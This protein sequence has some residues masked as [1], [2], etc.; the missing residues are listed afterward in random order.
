MSSVVWIRLGR[1]LLALV[2]CILSFLPAV[3]FLELSPV[4]DKKLIRS[5][6][7][8]GFHLP[9]EIF[10]SLVGLLTIFVA[11]SLWILPSA[12]AIGFAL[13]APVKSRVLRGVT[14]CLLLT[15][16]Y[17]WWVNAPGAVIASR[18]VA[19]AVSILLVSAAV[20]SLLR[21]RITNL[22]FVA[23]A[24]SFALLT[25]PAWI[26]LF[27]APPEP[28]SAQ[29]LWSVVLQRKA[30]QGMNTGSAFNSRRQ[31]VFA[32][33]RLVVSFDSGPAPYEGKQPMSNFR[34]LSLD[35]QT[36][37]VLNSKQ[38]VGHWGYMPLLFA[39][40]DGRAILQ[41]ESLKSLNPDLTDA[42]AQFMPDRGRVDQMSSDGSVMAW[43]TAPGTT[44]LDSR[45][46]TPLPQH[47]DESAPTSVSKRAV[48]TDNMRWYG[49]Y[50]DDH[51]FVT[52]T[53][54]SGKHLIF[55]DKCGGRPDFLTNEKVLIV[56]CRKARIIDIHGKF[57]HETKTPGGVPTFAGVSQDGSR[58][59][60][61]FS[62]V[63]GDPP[64]P[65]YDHFVIYDTETSKPIA[66]VRIADLP[67]YNSWSA[68]SSDGHLFAAGSPN[69]L[70]LYRVP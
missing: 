36:G 57:L 26:A 35:V 60:V 45:L 31:V 38:F 40:N 29:K 10:L 58:F 2:A 11:L 69:N 19:V 24:V 27:L 67:E 56:G 18:V 62:E 42:G 53:D 22:E 3:I 16:A 8:L 4:L 34:L 65:L 30:W 15:C 44:L 63:R 23:I 9:V 17:L 47:L 20:F 68:F 61:E 1:W 14:L 37:S 49:E 66:I 51:A 21:G 52:L 50:P 59:A 48:L 12:L 39:T 41:H 46:L 64:M 7:A 33:E 13:R 25:V 28:P 70:S 5:A 54:E 6:E 55:H 43:E 32:G